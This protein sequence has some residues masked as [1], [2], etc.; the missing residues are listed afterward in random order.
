MS[1]KKIKVAIVGASGYTGSELA[2]YLIH[3]PAVEISMITSESHAGKPFSAL[4]P[5]FIGQLDIPLVPAKEVAH[6]ALD[7]VFL[8]LPH[9]VSMQYVKQ[10]KDLSF[11]IIDLSG[12]FRLSTPAVYE[13]WYKKEHIFPEG[14]EGAVYGLPELHEKAIR[15]SK[16][17]ANPGCYPTTSILALAPL[18]A[19]DWVIRESVIVDAKSGITG[20]GIKPSA[21]SLF[22]N[23]NE[24]FKAYGLKSHRHTAEI[25]EQLGQLGNGEIKLQFT[26]HLLPVDR[27]IL[28]TAYATPK[29][30]VS[31]KALTELYQHFYKGK[32]FIRLREDLPAIKEV[33]ASNFCDIHVTYDERTNRI[34]IISA[35]DNLTKGASGQAVHNMNLMLGL[36][37]ETGLL[38]SPIKP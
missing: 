38:S 11:K 10:W 20:A 16:L 31:Q 23:V 14:F 17:V 18:L 27:G 9:G 21:T 24:N 26:P 37:E 3:H 5:Q 28:A 1:D 19:E 30:P 34:I 35:I 25:E 7:V 36:P 32:P 2:R 22:S 29:G 6:Q 15:A 12:D 8:A 33:R 4:H 13:K